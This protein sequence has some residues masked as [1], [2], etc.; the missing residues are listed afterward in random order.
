MSFADRGDARVLLVFVLL[1]VAPQTETTGPH[2]YSPVGAPT[3]QVTPSTTDYEAIVRDAADK[4]ATAGLDLPSLRVVFSTDDRACNGHLG[5]FE[6]SQQ[7]WR[8][9]ICSELAFVPVHELAHAWITSNVDEPT[10]QGYLQLRDKTSWSSPRLDW[11]ER[12][13]EDAAFVIQQN[14]T[15][16][17]AGDLDDEWNSRAIAFEFLTGT[18][19]PLRSWAGPRRCSRPTS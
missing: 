14:L 18:T 13:V 8:V 9:T 7:P 5:L 2:A 19:S 1:T 12:G 6:S 11:N 17:H 3:F 4:F 15:T 10:R 16:D